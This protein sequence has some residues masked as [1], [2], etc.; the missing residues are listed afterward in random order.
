MANDYE[1][2]NPQSVLRD[3][4]TGRMKSKLATTARRAAFAAEA[5]DSSQDEKKLIEQQ[6]AAE[7]DAPIVRNYLLDMIKVVREFEGP[8]LKLRTIIPILQDLMSAADKDT[9]MKVTERR[10]VHEKGTAL[11]NY[12]NDRTRLSTR[13]A[14]GFKNVVKEKLSGGRESLS[15]GLSSSGSL[16]GKVAGK[17][18]SK[19]ETPRGDSPEKQIASAKADTYAKMLRLSG[20][21]P[22][23]KSPQM[24]GPRSSMIPYDFDDDD[25][26]DE[27][28]LEAPPQ[29]K[30]K[31]TPKRVKKADGQSVAAEGTLDA[32]LVSSQAILQQLTIQSQLLRTGGERAEQQAEAKE[33]AADDTTTPTTTTPVAEKKPKRTSGLD[34]SLLGNL[35]KMFTGPGGLMATIGNMLPLLTKLGEGALVVGAG[36]LGWKVGSWV[37]QMVGLGDSTE[38]LKNLLDQSQESWSDTLASLKRT[39]SD[40]FLKGQTPGQVETTDA[41]RDLVTRATQAGMK[42]NNMWLEAGSNDAI[43]KDAQDYMKKKATQK[44]VELPKDAPAAAPTPAPTP[45]APVPPPAPIEAMPKVGKAVEKAK[46]APITATPKLSPMVDTTMAMSDAGIAAIMKHESFSAKPYMDETGYAIGYGSHTLGGV[47]V[48]E[49]M[50]KNPNLTITKEQAKAELKL[51]VNKEFAPAVRKSLKRKVS[52][53]EF[54]SLVSIAYN[55]GVGNLGRN[56][57]MDKVND[58]TVTK[59]D[60]IEAHGNKLDHKK[61]AAV[62]RRR[63]EE[64]AQFISPGRS[65]APVA[66]LTAATNTQRGSGGNVTVAPV[67]VQAGGGSGAVPVIMPPGITTDNPDHTIRAM[68]GANYT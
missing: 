56:H 33:R 17:L 62:E 7:D 26:D 14:A 27:S 40:F 59:Q 67:V 15:E 28:V 55:R 42:S 44:D 19:K 51:R 47:E 41:K 38:A 6:F 18:L 60:F 22:G 64:Y 4:K 21:A 25:D 50:K 30:K 43:Y 37:S 9:V 36:L 49:L 20:G 61:Q 13:M 11:V 35:L 57:F 58:G 12:I 68:K 1:G 52:Q 32:L 39:A 5:T 66:A 29:K 24:G 45:P 16:I 65:A 54:D 53:S 48:T 63:T 3:E 46:P 34:G 31:T 10:R 2:K 23:G 8:V